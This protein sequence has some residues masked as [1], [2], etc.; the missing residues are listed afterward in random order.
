[1]A[2]PRTQQSIGELF[3]DL[4]RDTATLIRQQMELARVE[5]SQR[6]SRLGKSL[7]G[8]VLGGALATGGLLSI[9]AGIV[10][11]IAALG[12]PAWISA[13]AVGSFVALIGYV[14]AQQAISSISRE[15]LT[16]HATIQTLKESAEWVK[17][18]TKT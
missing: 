18:P 2:D 3:G 11:A 17:S 10:L 1:M 9:I 16:P 6:F 13:L 15:D 14:T 12:V 7:G 8:V 5:L 4:S